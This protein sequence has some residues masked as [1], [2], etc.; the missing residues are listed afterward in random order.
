MLQQAKI[1]AL[2]IR[3]LSCGK[4]LLA[5]FAFGAALAGLSAAEA[6]TLQAIPLLAPE[7]VGSSTGSTANS[8]VGISAVRLA[9]QPK[10]LRSKDCT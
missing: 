10:A 4:R 2:L 7:Q 1:M 9:L 8:S 6:Q 3:K 5:A